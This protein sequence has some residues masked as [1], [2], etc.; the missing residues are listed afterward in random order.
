MAF[1]SWSPF[2]EHNLNLFLVLHASTLKKIKFCIMWDDKKCTFG[3]NYWP[4]LVQ[5]D[6]QSWT[7]VLGKVNGVFIIS[8]IFGFRHKTVYSF[9]N[10]SWSSSSLHPIQ[11]WHLVK[12]PGCN[13]SSMRCTQC[14]PANSHA[15]G[16]SLTPVGWKLRSH[17]RSRLRTNFS[18]LIEKCEL[19]PSCLTQ[20]PKIC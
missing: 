4:V 15:L 5:I 13:K 10:F 6:L 19:L 11:S 20:F 8:V 14:I 17:A 1:Q 12:N 2:N 7:K 18:R 16:V 3:S 9:W